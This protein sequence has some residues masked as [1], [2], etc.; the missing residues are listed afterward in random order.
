MSYIRRICTY[1]YSFVLIFGTRKN[2]SYIQYNTRIIPIDHCQ[3]LYIF[4]PTRI[5]LRNSRMIFPNVGFTV[6]YIDLYVSNCDR[7]LTAFIERIRYK[8]VIKFRSF[9]DTSLPAVRTECLSLLSYSMVSVTMF[10][11][12]INNKRVSAD[13][14]AV[15]ITRSI[16]YFRSYA[17]T[18]QV[19]FSFIF[20]RQMFCTKWSY[21]D[22]H[23]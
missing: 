21:L 3:V 2:S 13:H 15:F 16:L 9:F 17:S 14:W 8:T 7:G 18:K 10:H 23:T 20:W 19:R 22:V 6:L 11:G 1:H 12:V 4:C 5:V